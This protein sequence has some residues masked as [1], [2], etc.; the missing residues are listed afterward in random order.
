MASSFGWG[1]VGTSVG[2]QDTPPSSSGQAS[3]EPKT[4]SST[5]A[6]NK[7]KNEVETPPSASSKSAKADAN[8]ASQA[9]GRAGSV[10]LRMD[11]LSRRE[12]AVAEREAYVKELENKLKDGGI[13]IKPKNWP[14]CKPILY[15]NIEAEV[16]T[17]NQP[18]C[19]AGYVCWMLSVA[20][21]IFN[22]IAVTIMFFMG[23]GSLACWFFSALATVIGVF[24]SWW[25]W[26]SGLYKALQSRGGTF[27]YGKYFIHK[28]IF[29]G[30]AIWVVIAP[31]IGSSSCF[32][33]GFFVMIDQFGL[34]SSKGTT[35]GILGIINICLWGSTLI[36]AVYTIIWSFSI[37]KK[38]GG[39]EE[40][41]QHQE[42]AST[43][44]AVFGSQAVNSTAKQL[45]GGAPSFK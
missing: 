33:A 38:G 43:A 45:F 42:N 11:E 6:Q 27:A 17:P 20:S 32:V 14:K 8:R 37:W 39:L 24:C 4:Q 41:H 40:L 28:G 34:N 31:P 3:D 7:S 1:G 5:K 18:C 12:V 36:L 13:D 44:S 23:T 22:F 21:Y 25:T 26:Y 19:K 9:Q 2:P 30:W 29:I 10:Q 35:G 15:H 16:P